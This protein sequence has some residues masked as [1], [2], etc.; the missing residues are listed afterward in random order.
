MKHRA[1]WLC[2]AAAS[3]AIVAGSAVA[4]ECKG[5]DFPAQIQVDGGA[6]NLNGLGIRQA[7]VFKVNVYVAA[8]YI[9]KTSADANAI[10]DQRTPYQLI[11]HFVRDVSASDIN[12]SWGEGLERNAPNQLPALKDRLAMLT[13][14]MTDIKSGQ[15]LQFL[16]RP[17]TG[18]QVSVN[19]AV[20]GTI[21]GDDFARVFLSIWL[22]VPP[23]PEIKTGL[24]G[25]ACG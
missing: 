12:K 20:K 6:L 19:G 2:F 22:G 9:A 25:G 17:G 3:G 23:N 1:S 8:L 11:L 10:L 21:T 15:R 5:I 16:F 14:W 13:G 18:L 7:T 24:L 4:K